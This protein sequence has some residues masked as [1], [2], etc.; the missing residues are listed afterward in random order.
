MRP[1]WLL[2]LP[3]IGVAA[4]SSSSPE[5]ESKF[6]IKPPPASWV[7]GEPYTTIGRVTP[8]GSVATITTTIQKFPTDVAFVATGVPANPPAPDHTLSSFE[9]QQLS[10]ESLGNYGRLPRILFYIT[11]AAAVL[12]RTH[13]PWLYLGALA[14]S[15]TYSGSAAIHA[16]LLVWR[17]PGYGELDL[18]PLLGILS[19][20]CVIM[21]PLINWSSTIRTAGRPDLQRQNGD[22]RPKELKEFD[23]ASR[24]ILIFWSFL[25]T[26]GFLC[27]FIALQQG[28]R[29]NK[30]NWIPFAAI[31][32]GSFS[33]APESGVLNVTVGQPRE[34]EDSGLTVFNFLSITKEFL[35]ANNCLSPCSN[36]AGGP[37]IFRSVDEL[38]PLTM[39]EFGQVLGG[40]ST[41]RT[42]AWLTNVTDKFAFGWSY[43]IVYV[44]LQG[45]WTI[46]F[47]RNK[48]S[49]TRAVLYHFFTRFSISGRADRDKFGTFQR[50]G[51][52][53]IALS[54]YLW[55]VFVVVVAVP[56][57][58]IDVVL[59]EL[60][61]RRLPQSES[62]DHI[63][64]WAPYA[65]TGLVL[66]AAALAKSYETIKALLL[67]SG[68]NLRKIWRKIFPSKTKS[69]KLKHDEY[70]DALHKAKNV[71]KITGS[72]V[73]RQD[74]RG[75]ARREW[76]SFVKFCKDPEQSYDEFLE[77]RKPQVLCTCPRDYE[78]KKHKECV[79][80]LVC[81]DRTQCGD[82]KACGDDG[83][84]DA[85]AWAEDE[86]TCKGLKDHITEA[87]VAAAEGLTPVVDMTQPY[88]RSSRSSGY[89][90]VSQDSRLAPDSI[91]QQALVPQQVSI[92]QQAPV[93]V[94][95]QTPAPQASVPQQVFVPR[96]DSLPNPVSV[97][98]RVPVPQ[99]ASMASIPQQVVIA[100]A[101]AA[102]VQQQASTLTPPLT[103]A[104]TGN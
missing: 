42:Q 5:S 88:V 84:A 89:S 38:Q 17:G 37:A 36:P 28:Y 19:A 26:V 41:T 96:R 13:L 22:D 83:G 77:S 61:V 92:P 47:G 103:A 10:M 100:P 80:R 63:G 60:Y 50:R 6:T 78:C 104:A 14:A 71:L 72:F 54:A 101:V 33:C 8:T 53:A 23:A 9:T 79:H 86:C 2:A 66:F 12:L 15:L 57:L 48:P 67:Q 44:L 76:T 30:G 40:D 18:F 85:G 43:V 20:S 91:P 16:C 87:S 81:T 73:F 64:A 27:V 4:Q 24:I 99:R 65:S 95:Q 93:P 1:I 31:A 35:D 59:I 49:E 32:S 97:P 75:G 39:V 29:S 70:V 34:I 21:V 51:A 7:T 58:I 55:S 25:V 82:C 45:A 74:V 52:Q 56:L 102:P 46:C 11:I 94:S 68:G 90:A 62:A 3:L 69:S 98:K